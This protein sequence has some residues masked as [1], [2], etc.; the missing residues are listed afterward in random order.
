MSFNMQRTLAIAE[1][2]DLVKEAKDVPTK[3]SLLRQYDSETLRYILELAFHPNVGWWL[4]EG[5]PPYTPSS[6]LDTEGRLYKE[7]RTLPLYLYGNRPDLKKH[8]RENLFIGLLESLHPKD[9][10]LLIAV[11]D[12]QVEGL[13]V[14]TINEA[15]PGLIPNE[16]HS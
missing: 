15:F 5:A 12:K 7:A 9:A 1:I 3:V 10:V 2:L 8:Q 16:Q 11:K 14:A 6:L 13:N 4:P